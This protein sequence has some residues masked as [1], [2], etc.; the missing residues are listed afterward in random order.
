MKTVLIVAQMLSTITICWGQSGRAPT[1]IEAE[2]YVTAYAQHYSVPVALARAIVCARVELAA[3]PDLS[4]RRCGAHAVDARHSQAAARDR[5]LQSRPKRLRW[6]ALSR[7][8]DA[9]VS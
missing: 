5:P 6:R 2:Y 9:T 3:L 7:L 8:V 1:Q 4:E